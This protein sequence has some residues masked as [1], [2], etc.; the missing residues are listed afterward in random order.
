[1][2]IVSDRREETKG[3]IANETSANPITAAHFLR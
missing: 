3:K 2:D 1:M